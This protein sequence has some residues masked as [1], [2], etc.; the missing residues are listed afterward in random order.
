MRALGAD[1][2]QGSQPR[3]AYSAVCFNVIPGVGEYFVFPALTT[4]GPMRDHGVRG[5][6]GGPMDCWSGVRTPEQHL[7]VEPAG[8]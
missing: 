3:P 8:S 7:E 4:S 1:V 2:R 5:R 6:A